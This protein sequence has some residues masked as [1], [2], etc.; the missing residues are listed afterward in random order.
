MTIISGEI[1]SSYSKKYWKILEESSVTE[2]LHYRCTYRLLQEFLFRKISVVHLEL[3]R[4]SIMEF[5]CENF[6]F[7]ADLWDGQNAFELA[8]VPYYK[9]VWLEK[10][11]NRISFPP[12]NKLLKQISFTMELTIEKW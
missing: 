4:T 3:Y 12:S 6:I 9:E 8:G 2:Y 10:T 11:W 5:F 7:F 1:W